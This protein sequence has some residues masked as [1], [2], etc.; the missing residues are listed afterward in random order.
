MMPGLG[1]T[2]LNRTAFP[3]KAVF[4][5]AMKIIKTNSKF[6]SN[7]RT[8][9]GMKVACNKLSS[10]KVKS[11]MLSKVQHLRASKFSSQEVKSTMADELMLSKEKHLMSRKFSIQEY[12]STVADELLLSKEQHLM[13]IQYSSQKYKSTMA[14]EVMLS[15]VQ[16]LMVPSIQQYFRQ[17]NIEAVPFYLSVLNLSCCSLSMSKV[18]VRDVAYLC[19]VQLLPNHFETFLSLINQ[20]NSN[21]LATKVSFLISSCTPSPFPPLNLQCLL[22]L[23]IICRMK[24][25][26]NDDRV[27]KEKQLVHHQKCF[28]QREEMSAK[29]DWFVALAV[30]SVILSSDPEDVADEVDENLNVDGEAFEEEQAPPVTL[31]RKCPASV[32]QFAEKVNGN[33]R[34]NICKCCFVCPSGNTSNITSHIL[35]KH[36]NTA[37]ANKLKDD[38]AEKV[39]AK[40]A[41]E[42]VQKRRE[43]EGGTQASIS[44]FFTGFRPLTKKVKEEIDDNLVEYLICENESFETVESHFFRKMM[45]FANK[46][47]VM[48]SRST[49]TR[50]ID[51][52]IIKVKEELKAEINADI[53]VHKTISITSDGGSSGDLNKTKKNTLTVSR[54]TEDFCLKTDVISLPEAKGSQ[55]GVVIRSQWKEELMK[56]GYDSTWIVNAT[57]DGAS[58]FRSARNPSR[59]ADVGLPTKYTT[60]CLDHQ[61][62]LGVEES[63]KNLPGMKESL[64]KGKALRN[65]FSR[66]PLSRQLLR[67][68]QEELGLPLLCSVTGTSNRWFHKMSAVQRLL[69]IR[70]AVE[71]FQ[72]RSTA[73]TED[74]EEPVETLVETDWEHMKDYVMAVKGFETIS[75]F[76]GGQS[77]PV[78]TCVIP[79][80]DQMKE[81]MKTLESKFPRECE[82]KKL[83]RNLVQ[84][85]EKRFPK[86]WRHKN[87]FNCLTYLDPRY[88][89]MYADTD[90]LKEQVYD[91]IINDSVY[92]LAQLNDVSIVPP[93]EANGQVAVSTHAA[94][95]IPPAS[96]SAVPSRRAALLAKKH[97]DLL[98]VTLNPALTFDNKFKTEF[99]R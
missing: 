86:C 23:N 57:T 28:D 33:A 66:A 97:R 93:N 25:S 8:L 65:H 27:S 61:I 12:K 58:N 81:D 72:V 87:P 73:D 29:P 89:D 26:M 9:M 54:I 48:P 71:V 24:Y 34:C 82:G 2:L 83:A 68:I 85:M 94:S 36:K 70:D 13:T 63:I 88:V 67:S 42:E 17:Q 90:D 52:K 47:Y 35:N 50:K 39:K 21:S 95:D 43:K 96:S 92:D 31:K 22:L 60:D 53:S 41:K 62:H 46:S 75:K 7:I 91:D 30:G 38:L 64:K 56:I 15:W 40:K 80:L 11:P 76:F 20:P 78:G 3:S 6:E 77:Y 79:A 49:I 14:D 4:E 98:P 55:E 84:S 1:C 16:H 44:S 5:P 19:M 37:E 59:H 45:F 74:D 10:Q 69:E 32:W 99:A 51:A 18:R